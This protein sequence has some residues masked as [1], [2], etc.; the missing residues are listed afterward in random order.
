MIK[1]GKKQGER[2]VPWA[3]G[4]GNVK[5]KEPTLNLYFKIFGA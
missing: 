5:G 2:Q 4:L 3:D 1:N